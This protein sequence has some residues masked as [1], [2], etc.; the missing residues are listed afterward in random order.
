MVLEEMRYLTWAN[1]HFPLAR[2]DLG[3]S[4][5]PTRTVSVRPEYAGANLAD[6]TQAVALHLGRPA[7]EVTLAL[8]ASHGL[9]LAYAGLLAGSDSADRGAPEVLVET[10]VYEPLHRVPSGMGANVVFFERKA[11][12]NYAVDPARV[13]SLVNDRTRIVSLSNLHNPTGVRTSGDTLQE[14]ASKLAKVAPKAAL[15]VDEAYASF[16]VRCDDDG[17]FLHSARNLGPNV[18]VTSTLTKSFGYGPE[19]IGWVLANPETT[20][21][22]A[23]QLTANL[24]LLP[25]SI[26]PVGVTL[27]RSLA[28]LREELVPRLTERRDLCRAWVASHPQL[29]FSAPSE[30]L[31]G[32]VRAEG[33]TDLRARIERG[34]AE[35]GVI[36]APGSFFGDPSA[37]RLSWAA[38]YETLE[39][40]LERLT[41][42]LSL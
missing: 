30:G 34:L 24:G 8:G 19:R 12:E 22:I 6:L 1:R 5:E 26:A 35:Q 32:F 3:S 41:R 10:P 21:T 13:L 17:R 28:S 18:V 23:H 9:Y 39:P 25:R 20:R 4:G 16:D 11:E 7:S 2:F 31:F 42:V 38:P 15:L 36:V 37:F 14:L 27:F 40:S 33:L 29:S